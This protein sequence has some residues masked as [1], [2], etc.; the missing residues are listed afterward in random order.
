MIFK[1]KICQTKKQVKMVSDIL[2][3]GRVIVRREKRELAGSA[4]SR[5]RPSEECVR[6]CHWFAW[7]PRSVRV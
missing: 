5:S 6:Y 1:T 3:F 2:G 7:R 4:V